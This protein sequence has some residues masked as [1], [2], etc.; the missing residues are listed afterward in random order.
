MDTKS[1][2]FHLAATRKLGYGDD[3]IV[4]GSAEKIDEFKTESTAIP[5]LGKYKGRFGNAFVNIAHSA[6]SKLR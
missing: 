2:L 6:A 4:E 3:F 1:A 5:V